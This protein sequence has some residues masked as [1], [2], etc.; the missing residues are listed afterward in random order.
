ML[1]AA[2][3]RIEKLCEKSAATLTT[4]TK[5]DFP[6]SGGSINRLSQGSSAGPKKM[7][8]ALAYILAQKQRAKTQTLGRGRFFH[9]LVHPALSLSAAGRYRRVLHQ[10][11]GLY[12]C[13]DKQKPPS[14]PPSL[15]P[16]WPA[17]P[18]TT[19]G[20]P[21][22]FP[23]TRAR[24]FSLYCDTTYALEAFCKEFPRFFEGD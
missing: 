24:F 17:R 3:R 18:T 12:A 9:H 2:R 14:V 13:G 20:L 1:A 4:P 15:T 11:P 8:S 10:L 19:C 5:E 7:D 22:L 6:L 21:L 23:V 16:P